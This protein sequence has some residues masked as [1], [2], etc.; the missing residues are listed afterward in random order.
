MHDS[1]QL[2]KAFLQK[3]F[4]ISQSS[5]SKSWKSAVIIFILIVKS[6][7]A[8]RRCHLFE[9]V[10]NQYAQRREKDIYHLPFKSF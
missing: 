9:I 6:R 5:E 3:C 10:Q 1:S 8:E 2:R 4:S 7:I